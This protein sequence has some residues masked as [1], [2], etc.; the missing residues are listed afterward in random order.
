MSN[1]KTLLIKDIASENIR[2]YN[3]FS[4]FFVEPIQ[5][6]GICQATI[7]LTITWTTT[8]TWKLGSNLRFGSSFA[9]CFRCFRDIAGERQLAAKKLSFKVNCIQEKIKIMK[10][11]LYPNASNWIRYLYVVISKWLIFNCVRSELNNATLWICMDATLFGMSRFLR[12]TQQIKVKLEIDFL[13]STPLNCSLNF[14][15]YHNL[16][17]IIFCKRDEIQSV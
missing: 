17:Y 9:L 3:A 11:Q 14:I 7:A 5:G 1:P 4:V 8:R 6:G 13:Q 15:T 10:N 2:K 12:K 16:I